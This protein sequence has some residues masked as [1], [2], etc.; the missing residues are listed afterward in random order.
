MCSPLL[1]SKQ[2]DHKKKKAASAPIEQKLLA[3]DFGFDTAE[4]CAIEQ[5]QMVAVPSVHSLY[6]TIHDHADHHFFFFRSGLCYH[7]G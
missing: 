6:H 3:S 5:P 2:T 1:C 7:N 4:R